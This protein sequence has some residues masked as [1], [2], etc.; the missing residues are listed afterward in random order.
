MKNTYMPLDMLFV[1]ATG[2]IVDIYADA[3]PMDLTQIGSAQEV[4]SVIELNAGETAR[5]GIK[6]GDHVISQVPTEGAP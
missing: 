4:R 1:D 3:K 6:V 5:R 2:A